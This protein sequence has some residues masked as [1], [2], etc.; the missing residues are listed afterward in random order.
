[1]KPTVVAASLLLST[2][3]LAS[4]SSN[5]NTAD[6]EIKA[7]ATTVGAPSTGTN[8]AN[9][10]EI[11]IPALPSA[12]H[13]PTDNSE[14]PAPLSI[15][16]KSIDIKNAPIAGVGVED[17]GEMEVPG[18][19]DVG[20]YSFGAHPGQQGSSVLAAHIAAGGQNGVFRYLDNIEVDDIIEILY[21]GGKSER[22][23]VT[24]LKQYN[25]T[26][27]PFDDI[28]RRTGDPQLVLITCGGD[29]NPSE[30]SYEDNVV[31]FAVPVSAAEATD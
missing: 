29:F 14:L 2:A 18:I 4:C 1:M 9:S 11:Q 27:L 8:E 6:G 19:S 15:S 10:S 3:L 12:I 26:E 16:I 30:D 31:V 20:W 17:N 24:S 22:F 23:K 5:T 7:E 28:F 21:E 25:K 13:D